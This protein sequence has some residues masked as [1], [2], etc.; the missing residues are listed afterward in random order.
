MNENSLVVVGYTDSGS[1]VYVNGNEIP[2]KVDGS[3]SVSVPLK[4]GLNQI[5]IKTKNKFGKERVIKKVVLM[6]K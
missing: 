1:S 2:V 4:D 5:I 3:F 6:Q